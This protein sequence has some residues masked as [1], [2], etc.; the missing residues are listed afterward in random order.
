LE[1]KHE[2]FAGFQEFNGKS[3]QVTRFTK[4]NSD[5]THVEYLENRPLLLITSTTYTEDEVG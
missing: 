4:S 3:D 2:F 5:G 1:Q